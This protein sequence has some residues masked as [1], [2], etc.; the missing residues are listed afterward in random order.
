MAEL[1][2]LQMT[3]SI[4]SA[5]DSDSV[6]SISDTVES[7]Q[8]ATIIQNKYYDIL[9]RGSLPE[10]QVLFQFTPS[11]DILKPTLMFLP[12]GTGHVEWI[13]YFDSSTADSQQ[14]DQFGSFSH[15]LNT[16]I[17]NSTSWNTTSTTSNTIGTGTKTFTVASSSLP[18]ATG[19][20]VIALS[21]PNNM[22]GTVTS[23]IGTT[24]VLNVI[25]TGGSGTFSSW[26]LSNASTSAVAGYKY[27]TILPVDQFLDMINRFNPTDPNVQTFVF[28]EGVNSFNF[29]YKTN[30]QPQY[31]A[32]L[33]N[34]YVIFD[35]YDLNF[36]STLQA[37]KTLVYGQVVTPFQ[38]LD[39]FVPDMDDNKFPLLLNEAKSLAF[40]ELKQMPHLKAD[41]EIK[42]QWS[43]VQKDKAVVNKPSYF[44]QLPNFGR[45]P[46][47]GGYASGGYA[48][49]KWMRQTGP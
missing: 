19:Q 49:Y 48:A 1:T 21:G 37:S 43:S 22:F 25:S 33:E 29:Y 9:T 5:L 14:V 26:T 11:V 34:N 42:R 2:V 10:Q 8:V 15:N 46:R 27:V 4:L 31:C 40:Y 3:Q 45:V 38:L 23:Y 41:Q 28:T 39:S 17:V 7:M 16:D 30:H 13:K 6:N 32:V 20:G 44:E 47:T 35:S 36:D 24:L 18:I 12:A